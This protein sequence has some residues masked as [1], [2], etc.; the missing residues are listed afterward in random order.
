MSISFIALIIFCLLFHYILIKEPRNLLSGFSLVLYILSLLIFIVHVTIHYQDWLSNHAW[1]QSVFVVIGLQSTIVLLAFPVLLILVFLIEGIRNIEHEGFCFSNVL[2]V[3]FAIFM[4]IYMYVW[5][6]I[7]VSHAS[8]FASMLYVLM[9]LYV[10]YM[11]IVM[12]IFYLSSVVNSAHITKR[13]GLDYIVVLGCGVAG[14]KVTPLLA[15]RIEKGIQVLNRNK[16]AKIIFS[17]GQGNGEDI[18]EGIAMK[19]YALQKGVDENRILVESKS[20]N[21]HENLMYSSELMEKENPRVA[22]VTTN[23]HVFRSLI[24]AKDLGIKCIGFGAHTKWYFSLN[25]MIREF[26]GY[27]SISKRKHMIALFVLTVLILIIHLY[28]RII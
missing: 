23:Y 11:L 18:A 4:I 17:G 2:A 15:S 25:A 20:R 24:I 19:N 28:A 7:D 26:V 21:T 13:R 22:L 1:I 27:L 12:T 8:D 9:S 6:K 16:H 5:P 3:L 14:E 10:L